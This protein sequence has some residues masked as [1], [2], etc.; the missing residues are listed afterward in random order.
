MSSDAEVRIQAILD[1]LE[2]HRI[3]TAQAA[4]R[5]RAIR[6]PAPAARTPFDTQHADAAGD[7]HPPEPGSFFA[8]S[9]AY[10][11]GRIDDEQYAALAQAAA[12]AAKRV[13]G[14]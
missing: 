3:S 6:F 14:A 5:I 4:A 8:V 10:A 13:P 7:H 11:E 2:H 12:E 1:W 9:H